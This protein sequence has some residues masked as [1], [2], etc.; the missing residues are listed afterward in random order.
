MTAYRDMTAEQML[1]WGAQESAARQA[2]LAEVKSKEA[3]TAAQ[4]NCEARR[5]LIGATRGQATSM[6]LQANRAKRHPS[7]GS[8]AEVSP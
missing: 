4:A 7:I 6:V 2:D 3:L 5:K 1:A 8:S